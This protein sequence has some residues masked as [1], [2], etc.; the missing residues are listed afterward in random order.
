MEELSMKG[1]LTFGFLFVAGVLLLIIGGAILLAPHTVHAGNGIVLGNDPTLLSEIRAPG[2]L[3][4]GSAILILLGTFRPGMRS[5]AVTLTVLAYGSFGLARLV[6][7]A[8]DGVPATGIVVAT[9]IELVTAAIGA[10]L[11]RR[12][13]DTHRPDPRTDSI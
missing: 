3:L 6:G 5:L 1:R 11:L 9:A 2:G 7:V 4:L 12:P 8:L 13:S 10:M